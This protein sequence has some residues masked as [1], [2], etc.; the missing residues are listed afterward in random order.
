MAVGIY[1][2]E[3]PGD[4]HAVE[5]Q[6]GTGNRTAAERADVHARVAVPK[7]LAIAFEHLDVGEQMV[8]EIDGLRALQVRVA[9]NAHVGI[10]LAE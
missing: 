4:E 2:A 10:L 8:R 6:R 7:A 3:Q 9:G 1:E 5:R